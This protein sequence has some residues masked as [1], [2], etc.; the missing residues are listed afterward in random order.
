MTRPASRRTKGA[1]TPATNTLKPRVQPTMSVEELDERLS[2]PS[3]AL[4]AAMGRLDGDILVLGVGGKMGPSLAELAVRALREAGRNNQV[5]GVSGFSQ[6]G[7]QDSLEQKGIACIKVNLLDNGALDGLPNASNV[8]NMVGRKFGST[9]AEWKTW[10]T[11][12]LLSGHIGR[13]FRDARIAAFSS[14]NIYPFVPIASGGCDETAP[15]GP[16]G[17]YAI[18]CVGRERMMDLAAH[19]YGTQVIH[20][21]L[22]YANELRYG[23]IH[24]IAHRIWDRQ[25]VD[26]TMG[27]V[28]L[29][30][31]GY[32]NSVALQSLSLVSSPPY[33]LNIA[34]P[35]TVSIRWL[36]QRLGAIM[37][38]EPKIVGEEA[39]TAL[40]SNGSKCH[41]LF[42]YPD[43]PLGELIEW[44]ARWVMADGASLNKPT[45]FDVRDGK[46]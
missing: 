7:L 37:D 30:W 1:G 11:N 26:V 42:G 5:I 6:E 22:N 17:E 21:R 16:V 32:A 38:R 31:Q 46:F 20:L 44:V 29:V 9:G 12:V 18:T 2:R 41:K 28:N 19:E 10:E 25:P 33:I 45:H 3:K 39:Q 15:L 8:I 13:R 40:L 35:E 14:G 4:I 43:V 23:I 36:A 24:D 27:H 34:G